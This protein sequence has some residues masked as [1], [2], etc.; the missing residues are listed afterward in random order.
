M[1]SFYAVAV[2]RKTGVFTNWNECKENIDDFK[3][4]IFKKFATIEEATE[5]IDDYSN[6]LYVYT[7]GSCSNNG[8]SNARAGIGIF[9]SKDSCLNVSLELEGDKLTNNV[10]ELKAMI[11][12]IRII[13]NDKHLKRYKNKII[14]TDSEYGIKCATTY[15]TK[16][17]EKDWKQKKDKPIPNLELV[18]ELYDLTQEFGIKYKHIMAHTENK[19]RHSIGNYYA[20]LLAN[21][22]I[23]LDEKPKDGFIKKQP[24]IYLKVK[25]EE[26]EDAKS[27]GAKWDPAKKQWYIFEDNS[28]KNYLINKYK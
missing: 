14:V 23:N 13:E 8:S 22:A 1:S 27:K 24:K 25:Y 20:D 6:N 11:G 7:D 19:D 10:A 15:G 18:K 17:A 5:F 12:A 16:L 2:G 21:K 28:N 3:G 26:K 4:A 9:F